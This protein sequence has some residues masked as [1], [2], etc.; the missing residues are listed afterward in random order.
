[1]KIL[2]TG[3]HGMLGSSIAAIA[4][5]LGWDCQGLL[6]PELSGADVDILAAILV[7]HDALIHAAANT[8]V[9]QCEVDP[10]KCYADNF[11]LTDLLAQAAAL[12]NVRMVF[13]SSTGVY[14]QGKSTAYREYDEAVPTTHHHRSKLLGEHAVMRASPRNLVI[15]TGWLFGGDAANPK[16]FVARRIDEARAAA[17]RGGMIQ[18]NT[19][20]QG[21]PC[22]A[23]DVARRMLELADASVSGVFNCVNRGSASRF[24]YVNA[25][26]ALSQLPVRVEGIAAGSFGR[27]ATVS[28]NETAEN[29]KMDR[30]G[31]APM[32]LWQESLTLYVN[33][34]L[35]TAGDTH[36]H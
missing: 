23:I 21:T 9:E 28:N 2:L 20:Q 8:N 33:R 25:I 19:E 22:F 32:P 5:Q 10:D 11:L 17:A 30:L 31:W 3:S 15:R 24:D 36:G 7:G 16:N 14:G 35:S 13:V 18:S 26:V 29:W 4:H 34:E 1:M 12:A 27:K 6:R